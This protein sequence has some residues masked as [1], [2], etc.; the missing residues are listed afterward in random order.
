MKVITKDEI[1]VDQSALTGESMPVI[2]KVNDVLYSGSVIRRGEAT[3]LIVRT[4]LNTFFGKTV[5]L[6]QIARPKLHM[7]EIRRNNF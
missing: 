3:G 1:E 4:G 6:V 7:E 5:Q 2:K